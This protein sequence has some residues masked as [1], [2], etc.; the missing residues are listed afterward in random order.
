MELEEYGGQKV[1]EYEECIRETNTMSEKD[2]LE[3]RL[4]NAN[5]YKWF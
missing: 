4:F 2:L 1:V 5:F 3:L